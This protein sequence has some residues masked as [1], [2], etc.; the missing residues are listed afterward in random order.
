[1]YLFFLR[2]QLNIHTWHHSKFTEDANYSKQ[3]WC[4]CQ[5]KD[6]SETSDTK[7]HLKTFR[8]NTSEI[9]VLCILCWWYFGCLQMHSEKLFKI[10]FHEQMF[11]QIFVAK[12][13]TGQFFLRNN[14]LWTIRKYFSEEWEQ[15]Y[16]FSLN[17][18]KT[19]EGNSA[20]I[21]FP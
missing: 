13:D 15:I 12:E 5:S 3:K 7:R 9:R 1:M 11:F 18:S 14:N 17:K 6:F 4:Y 21:S 16:R 20:A 19:T 2:G 8:I 10:Y